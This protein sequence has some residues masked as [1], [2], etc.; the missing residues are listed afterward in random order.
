MK[1]I[2]RHSLQQKAKARRSGPKALQKAKNLGALANITTFMGYWDP[3]H[4]RFRIAVHVPEGETPPDVNS[5][6][7]NALAESDSPDPRLGHQ[8]LPHSMRST[9]RSKRQQALR[10]IERAGTR[11]PPQP[12]PTVAT[13]PCTFLGSSPDE[14]QQRITDGNSDSDRQNRGFSSFL[15]ADKTCNDDF[16]PRNSAQTPTAHVPNSIQPTEAYQNHDPATVEEGQPAGRTWLQNASIDEIEASYSNGLLASENTAETQPAICDS[17]S[18]G[19]NTMVLLGRNVEP[20]RRV[21]RTAWRH[22]AR[23]SLL[24]LNNMLQYLPRRGDQLPPG[25]ALTEPGIG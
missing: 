13:T 24:L 6:I 15:D 21:S 20:A 22:L 9:R 2:R 14:A 17:R 12:P 7:E 1:Q 25:Y 19:T 18:T 8:T 4:L 16:V 5:L 3:T 10:E 23:D 11:T